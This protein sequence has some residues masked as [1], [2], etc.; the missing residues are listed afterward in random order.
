MRVVTELA[1][2]STLSCPDTPRP[3][4]IRWNVI[5]DPLASPEAQQRQHKPIEH[6]RAKTGE[7]LSTE[8]AARVTLLR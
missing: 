5:N 1:C 8:A 2:A 4:A 7:K 6:Q 3:D